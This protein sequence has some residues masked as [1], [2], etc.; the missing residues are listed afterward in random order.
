MKNSMKIAFGMTI[1]MVSISI[2]SCSKSDKQIASPLNPTL[3]LHTAA[4]LGDLNSVQQHIKA[5][6]DLN[7]K[8]QYGSSPL[9][10]AIT[11]DR[12]EVSQVLIE[13]GADLT[14][15]NNDG[16]TPL[17]IAAFFCRPGTVKLLLDNGADKSIRNNYGAT[18]RETVASSFEEVRPIY[19]QLG[20]ALQPL[21][22]KLDYEY[23]KTTRPQ[24]AAILK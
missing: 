18:A 9:I 17:H 24:I 13:A 15:V 16:S 21:G 6:T 14:V 22:F 8:D 5:G 2:A 7:Q 11:F 3:D 4:Y 23:L 20:A 12:V 19:D 1:M 10:I